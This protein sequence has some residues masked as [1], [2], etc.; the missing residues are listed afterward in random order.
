M[1]AL[2][3]I[4]GTALFIFAGKFWT[5]IV[6]VELRVEADMKLELARELMQINGG[7]GYPRDWFDRNEGGDPRKAE[8]KVEVPTTKG[9]KMEWSEL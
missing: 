3:L 9:K 8:P 5:D 4:C 2:F 6:L 7:H 1:K